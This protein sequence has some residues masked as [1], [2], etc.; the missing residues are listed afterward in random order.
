MY[1][2]NAA[3]TTYYYRVRMLQK[4]STELKKSNQALKDFVFIASHLLKAP[5]SKIN[6]LTHVLKNLNL[7]PYKFP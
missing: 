1:W 2:Q 6:S 4:K 7:P 5:L 3:I